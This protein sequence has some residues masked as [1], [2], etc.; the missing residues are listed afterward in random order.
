MNTT[1]KTLERIFALKADMCW[2][3]DALAAAVGAL[4]FR[5]GTI[6]STACVDARGRCYVNPTF[7]ATLKDPELRFVMLHEALHPMLQH[8][9]R[10]GDRDPMLWNIATDLSIN[11]VL[12]QLKI[13]RDPLYIRVPDSALLPSKHL[14]KAPAFASAEEYYAWLTQDPTGKAACQQATGQGDGD[15]KGNG[16]GDGDP[17]VG[18]GCGVVESPDGEDDGK[19]GL[20]PAQWRLIGQ[21]VQE[22]ARRAAGAGNAALGALANLLNIPPPRVRWSDLLRKAAVTALAEAG[23][24]DVSWNRR[25]RRSN[26]VFTLPGTVITRARIAVVIDASG[27]VSDDALA[28]AVSETAAAVDATGVPAYLVVHDAGVHHAGWIRPGV[29]GRTVASFIKGRGGTLFSPAYEKV[30]ELRDKFG[31]LVHFTDGLPCEAWPDLPSNCKRGL[32]AL[33]GYASDK[34]VPEHRWQAVPVDLR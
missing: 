21:V 28:R 6:S 26:G 1:T 16:D 14:P 2:Q 7:I 20:S 15:G 25:S 24:D 29:T 10:R 32:A 18:A 30:G 23:R 31:S 33:I 27:S 17:A 22:D 13:P 3:I 19:G 5:E 12:S 34:H 4:S 9:E 8:Q 11:S